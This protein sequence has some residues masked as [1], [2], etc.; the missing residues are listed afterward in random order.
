[1]SLGNYARGKFDMKNPAKYVGKK[2]PTYR[3]SW[4]WTFM[5]FCD[6]HPAIKHW[7]SETISI[8]Y[9]NVVKQKKAMYV[10]DFFVLYEDAK[11]NTKAEVVEIKPTKETNLK[12][13]GKSAY[14]QAMAVMNQ[15]KWQAADKW[16]KDQGF[17]FRIITEKELFH[18]PTVRKRK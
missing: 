16:C 11:G 13:A 14:N 1:M 7:S 3:S 8:P 18:N 10:P 15:C 17:T 5:N 12:E 6:N 4:E 2:T 9:Y